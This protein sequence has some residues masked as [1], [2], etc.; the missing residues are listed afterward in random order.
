MFAFK[1]KKERK[2]HVQ[3]RND[4]QILRLPWAFIKMLEQ[5]KLLMKDIVNNERGR[6]RNT[7]GFLGSVNIPKCWF[8]NCVS[9]LCL[10]AVKKGQ[11]P[12]T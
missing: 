6:K 3:E 7:S 4:A 2:T 8:C 11:L 1:D 9:L 10:T 5:R 12:S